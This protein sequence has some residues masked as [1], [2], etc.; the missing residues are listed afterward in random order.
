MTGRSSGSS[1]PAWLQLALTGWRRHQLA[2]D[3]R[4]GRYAR[5]ASRREQR[6]FI[7]RN[8]RMFT[9]VGLGLLAVLLPLTLL[10]PSGYVRGFAG[11]ASVASVIALLAFWVVQA[12]GTAA[13]MMGDD[14]ERWTASELRKMQR[15]GWRVVNHVMWEKHDVDHVLVGPGGVYVVET[16]WSSRSWDFAGDDP[17]LQDAVDRARS[18]ARSLQLWL[19]RR[20]VT[21]V[22]PVVMLWGS[23]TADLPPERS[24]LSRA[25]ATVVV[26]P[27]ADRWRSSL[28]DGA[29]TEA[30]IDAV[31]QM[32]DQ[33]VETRDPREDET[34]PVPHSVTTLVLQGGWAFVSAI[35]GL[36]ITL[37][38]VRLPGPTWSTLAVLAGVVG[39][40]L[41]LVRWSRTARFLS[42][43]WLAGVVSGA[44]FV[45]AFVI[46]HH[47]G[48][49]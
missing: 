49:A 22:H 35:L 5:G 3:S 29:L 42:L 2:G 6:A 13:T 38:L 25:D 28:S 8:W 14:A 27:H 12:T 4:A 44:L 10:L 16:K 41:A 9:A 34:A 19:R 15:Q 47:I 40:S 46:A 30:Q 11:G 43:G 36:L 48:A 24:V 31:W 17:R 26:G 45:V 23:G 39:A 7:R 33:Y 20:G 1:V 18:N 21:V 37:E 32:L